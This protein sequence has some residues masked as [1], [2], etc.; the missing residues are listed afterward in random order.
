[1]SVSGGV[2]ANISELTIG[3]TKT[4]DFVAQASWNITTTPFTGFDPTML[5]LYKVQYA[6]LGAVGP[7]FSVFNPNTSRYVDVHRV[8]WANTHTTPNFGNPNLKIGWTAASLGAS[9]TN[10]TV[11]GASAYTAIQGKE[12]IVDTSRAADNSVSSVNTTLTNI[13]TLKN[14]LTFGNRFNLVIL[15]D[16]GSK[17]K[18]GAKEKMFVSL[19]QNRR[20]YNCSVWTIGQRYRDLSHGHRSN[21]THAFIFRPKTYVEADAI[22]TELVGIPQKEQKEFIKFLYDDGRYNHLLI[23]FTQYHGQGYRF[24]KTFKLIEIEKEK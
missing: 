11:Q 9:G 13:I 19:M 23:D 4:K 18:G 17:L 10:L 15:D 1:M 8:L 5:N 6:Y 2:T 22:F 24:Y 16:V 20:H 12:L 3:A 14:R 7:I 21:L